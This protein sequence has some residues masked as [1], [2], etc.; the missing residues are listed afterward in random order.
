MYTRFMRF[1]LFAIASID[2]NLLWPPL[3]KEIFV[4]TLFMQNAS[5]MCSMFIVSV[6]FYGK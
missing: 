1:I 3:K 6:P 5:H 2:W 4:M